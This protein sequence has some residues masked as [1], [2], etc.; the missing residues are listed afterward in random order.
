MNTYTENFEKFTSTKRNKKT[1]VKKGKKD[2]FGWKTER[3]EVRKAKREL[4][5]GDHT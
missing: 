4:F 5:N 1:K 3:K 2:G